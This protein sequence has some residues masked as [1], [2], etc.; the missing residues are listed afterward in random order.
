VLL[1]FNGQFRSIVTLD[2]QTIVDAGQVSR[3]ELCVYHDASHA[4]Y[5]SY[6]G[7]FFIP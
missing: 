4:R 6:S 2:Q 7:Q 1:H 5:G 3:G